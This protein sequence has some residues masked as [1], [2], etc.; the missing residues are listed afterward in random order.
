MPFDIHGRQTL[1]ERGDARCR[2]IKYK[3]AGQIGKQGLTLTGF[4]KGDTSSWGSSQKGTNRFVGEQERIAWDQENG[5]VHL[6]MD[7]GY[8]AVQTA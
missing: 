6:R 2:C 7:P 5:G 1:H 4:I 8:D 3:F